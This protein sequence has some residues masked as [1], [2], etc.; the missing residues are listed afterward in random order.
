[1]RLNRLLILLFVISFVSVKAQYNGANFGLSGNFI[2]TTTAKYYPYPNSSDIIEGSYSITIDD[3]TSFS[4]EL[5]YKLSE[6]IF[7][8]ANVEFIEAEFR[9]STKLLIGQDYEDAAVFDRFTVIPFEISL[10][11]VLPF[12][13]EKFK[14]LMEGGAA[15]YYGSF[16]R[17]MGDAAI[18]NTK[19]D[20]AYGIHTG[21]SME[22]LF[23]DYFILQFKMKF[24][25]P[26]VEIE[27]RYNS[28]T[29][30]INGR[31]AIIPRETFASKLNIDGVSFVLGISTQ[32]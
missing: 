3:I 29:V 20:F 14:F 9:G 4:A 28:N 24:R 11:Y 16:D 1:M 17:E 25:D 31:E 18:E 5:K 12:S 6:S 15:Y 32:F 22:Y 27:S 8:G 7:M 10:Y 26:E 30:N 21:L 13:G 2:Y 19:K 23:S